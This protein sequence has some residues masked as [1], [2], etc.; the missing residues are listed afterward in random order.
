MLL[1]E[2]LKCWKIVEFLK[3]SV[4]KFKTFYHEKQRA[5]LR[6]LF[7]LHPPNKNLLCPWNKNF[8]TELSGIYRHPEVFPS[9]FSYHRFFVP[10]LVCEMHFCKRPN[11]FF[12]HQWDEETSRGSAE[13]CKLAVGP[14]QSPGGGP[15]K[16][17]P[18]SSV[19]LGFKNLLF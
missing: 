10:N 13:Y 3:I 5:V 15:R 18:G 6:K 4:K 9:T 14:G 16:K 1:M 2:V 17:A 7:S 8:L 11:A 12:L 19:Y